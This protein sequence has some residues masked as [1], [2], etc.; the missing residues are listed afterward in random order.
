MIFPK[1]KDDYLYYFFKDKVDVVFEYINW[2]MFQML[3][4]TELAE[5]LKREEECSLLE[6]LDITSEDIV[7]KF[8]DKVEEKYDSLAEE[9]DD[10]EDQ[11]KD[12]Q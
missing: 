3:T 11:E 10:T 2:D 7:E 1:L 8:N 5:K 4:V 6:L 12:N 9:F